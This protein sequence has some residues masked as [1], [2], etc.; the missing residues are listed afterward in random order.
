MKLK[1]TLSG[2]KTREYVL[3][4]INVA[5]HPEGAPMLL[6]LNKKGDKYDMLVSSNLIPDVDLLEKIEI[7]E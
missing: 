4:R 5:P 7:V 1:V 3:N 6:N 2:G